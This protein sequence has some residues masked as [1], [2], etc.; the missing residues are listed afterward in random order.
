MRKVNMLGDLNRQL[1]GLAPEQHHVIFGK[2]LQYNTTY[3]F[4]G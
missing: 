1:R 3:A 2:I 4:D